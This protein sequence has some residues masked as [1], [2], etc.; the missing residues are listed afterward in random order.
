MRDFYLRDIEIFNFFWGFFLF[1]LSSTKSVQFPFFGWLIKAIEAPTPVSSLVHSRTLVT[2]GYFILIFFICEIEVYLCFF[3]CFFSILRIFFS[4]FLAIK[5]LDLKQ[6]VAWR[7]MSQVSLFFFFY[8]CGYYFYSFL[9][10]LS[11]AFFKRLLFLQVGFLIVLSSG[12]QD[13][14]K[15]KSPIFFGFV[16]LSF[17]LC[18]FCLTALIFL[19]GILRK[20][21]F[22]EFFLEGDFGFFFSLIIFFNIVLTFFYSLKILKLL[23]VFL[24]EVKLSFTYSLLVVDIFF[25]FFSFY[26]VFFLIE[27]FFLVGF[28]S[29]FY[30]I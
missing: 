17:L 9:H 22:L 20:D 16:I 4:S 12:D 15:M 24:L 29:N 21:L 26:F 5:E 13:Y 14:R 1:L 30:C 6:L 10:M 28:Y 11:H 25:S 8:G 7:T 19:S 18:F 23:M 2:A 27:N 3:L